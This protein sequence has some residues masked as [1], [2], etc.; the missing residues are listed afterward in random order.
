MDFSD[1]SDFTTDTV[2]CNVLTNQ[3]HWLTAVSRMGVC[4]EIAFITCIKK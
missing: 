4:I 3:G 2:L 1:V